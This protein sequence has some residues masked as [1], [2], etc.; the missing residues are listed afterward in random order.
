MA[1]QRR[2][3]QEFKKTKH[4]MLQRPVYKHQK[5]SLYVAILLLKFK[6]DL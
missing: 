2:G 4:Q 3:G 5:N 6:D 1:R